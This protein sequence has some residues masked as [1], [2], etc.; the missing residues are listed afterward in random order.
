MYDARSRLEVAMQRVLTEEV[1][2]RELRARI[3]PNCVRRPVGS[4]SLG[5]D[6]A[7]ACE[8]VCTIFNNLERL[9]SIAERFAG[10]PLAGYERAIEDGI[11][12]TCTAVPTAGDYCADRFARTC[13]LSIYAAD[14][15]AVIES[16]LPSAAKA[17]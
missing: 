13:P 14:V 17:Q 10:D 9:K 2:R 12:Q 7:R 6:V 5:P 3:C 8:D 11:C 15:L 1:L 16:L 4:A